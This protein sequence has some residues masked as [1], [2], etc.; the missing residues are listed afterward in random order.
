MYRQMVILSI[1]IFCISVFSVS[2]HAAPLL[3]DVSSDHWAQNA[4]AS[5]AA[6]GIM[7][8]YPDGLFKGDRAMTRNEMAVVLARLLAKNDREHSAFATKADLDDLKK[9]SNLLEDELN[10]QGVRITDMESDVKTLRMRMKR[11]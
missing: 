8:G 1:F 9:L 7:E 2:A 6:N 5:L 3:D 11:E 4:V 10:G